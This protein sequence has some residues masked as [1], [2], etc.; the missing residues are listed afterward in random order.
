MKGGG[1]LYAV[2]MLCKFMGYAIC[3]KG[4]AQIHKF[5]KVQ[6]IHSSFVRA[7]Y[8]FL[9]IIFAYL[10]ECICLTCCH[11]LNIMIRIRISGQFVCGVVLPRFTYI[12]EDHAY[13]YTCYIIICTRLRI[14]PFKDAMYKTIIQ[15]LN[16]P[17]WKCLIK[18]IFCLFLWHTCL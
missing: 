8:L 13:N 12:W 2:C 16:F 18:N 3:T 14:P 7:S 17:D 4:N 6:F 1:D 5:I 11:F 10:Y 9:K 15:F